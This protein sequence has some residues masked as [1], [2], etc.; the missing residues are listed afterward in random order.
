M[1]SL[2]KWELKQTFK[3]KAFWGFAVFYTI[4]ALLLLVDISGTD[5]GTMYNSF[6]TNMNNTSAFFMLSLG[7]FCGIHFAGA[8]EERRIQAAIMAGNSRMSIIM[9][10][11]LSFSLV[12]TIYS[13]LALG[14]G[15]IISYVSFEEVG[16]D[17]WMTPVTQSLIFTFAWVSFASICFITSMLVKK[18]GAAIA[19]NV[20]TFLVSDL[21]AQ[22]VMEKELGSKIIKF[23]PIGQTML[24]LVNTSKADITTSV[25]VSG[26]GLLLTF[27][28]ASIIFRRT[29]LK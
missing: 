14:I 8:F 18:T 2:I 11:M 5:Q 25:L 1:N 29:E 21:V 27:V 23:T 15:S 10:K 20:V 19:I 4:S 17:S 12:M 22:L 13:V 26:I 9:S 3:S 6:L 16:V 28:I 7:I 24:S